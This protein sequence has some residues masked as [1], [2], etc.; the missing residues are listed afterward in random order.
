M[1][2]GRK[3]TPD[4]I[5]GLLWRRRWLLITSV[6]LCSLGGLLYARS[7]P[8]LYTS[9]T[10]V[11]VLP[12]RVPD[13]Y[14]RA[15]VTST[16]EERLK[17]ITEVVRSRTQ[18]EQMIQE[19]DLYPEL[20]KE[21]SIEDA[22][23]A[24]RAAILVEVAPGPGGRRPLPGQVSAFRV[25]FGY[26]VRP[27]A[28]Q[29]TERI[30][31]LL[32]AENA[33]MRG[34]LADQTSEFM[35]TT[36]AEADRKLK[37]Q[38]AKL[39]DFRRRNAGRL[40]NQLDSNM[41]AMQTL[42]MELQSTIESL[43]RD[44]DSKAVLERLYDEAS[45]EP[46]VVVATPSGTGNDPNALPASASAQQRL[47]AARRNLE[48]LELR[49]KPEHPDIARAK[50]QIRD[51]EAQ[52]AAESTAPATQTSAPATA[53]DA[54]RRERLRQQRA[55]IDTLT[56]NISFKE[57]QERQLRA[58][59]S[60]YRVRID[61]IPS[62]ESEYIELTRNYDTLQ[63]NYKVLLGKSEESKVA[64]NLERRQIGEQFRVLD[65]PRISEVGSSNHRLQANLMGVLMG[66]LLGLGLVGFL[67]FRDTTYRTETDVLNA[68]ALPVLAAVPYAASTADEK[69]ET[70]KRRL[71]GAVASITVVATIGLAW[72]LRLWKF[73]A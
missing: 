39:E 42:R 51:L 8:E 4:D 13:A 57:E 49:L 37:E 46:A 7:L 18:L 70:R 40:P 38:E 19:F 29:V 60:D 28:L 54:A 67:E 22:V 2:P 69:R 73:V 48:A 23:N 1:L 53:E 68:L 71:V 25:S 10:L 62:V 33:R 61:A 6:F 31:Q 21:G 65:P 15:T 52:A 44:R 16:V 64:A 14:V 35:Q 72:Y 45:R 59:L 17:T 43:Q 41:Q 27:T 3:Y 12:Q 56:R 55:Q 32:I 9:E 24:L 20:R 11:Q 26:G 58:Q 30:T 50:R 5:L 66:V 34:N 47:A 63:E 36:L